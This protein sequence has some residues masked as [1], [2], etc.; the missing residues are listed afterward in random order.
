MKPMWKTD[1]SAVLADS[2]Y[3]PLNLWKKSIFFVGNIF[4]HQLKVRRYWNHAVYFAHSKFGKFYLL[5]H[6]IYYTLPTLLSWKL[7]KEKYDLIC[8]GFRW[9]TSPDKEKNPSTLSIIFTKIIVF[10]FNILAFF[11][12][13]LLL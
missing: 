12:L 3:L 5:D 13:C 4:W 8:L 10:N 11:A 6:Q 7:L 1:V 2:N 9:K